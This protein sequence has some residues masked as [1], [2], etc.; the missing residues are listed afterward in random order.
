MH[1]FPTFCYDQNGAKQLDK[2]AQEYNLSGDILMKRAAVAALAKLREKWPYAK[3]IKIFCGVG[4]NAG[5]GF[6]LARLAQ[7][8]GMQVEIITIEQTPI[9]RDEAKNAFEQALNKGIPIASFQKSIDLQDT[10]VI[11][12]AIFGIGLT[13]DV[14]GLYAEAIMLINQ[15][16]IP[17]FSIDIPSGLSPNTGSCLGIAIDASATITF[18]ALKQGLLTNDGPDKTGELY[19][20]SLDVPEEIYD[21]V[22]PTAR[23][24]TLDNIHS[25]LAPRLRNAHKGLYGHVLMVGGNQGFAGAMQIS[26][27]GAVRVGAGL[28]SIATHPL[29]ASSIAAVRPELMSHAVE[30]VD[31]MKLLLDRATVIAIGPGLGQDAWAQGLLNAVINQDKPLVVDADALNQLALNPH[32]NDRWILTPH[33]GEAARLLHC[34]TAEIQADRFAAAE[35]IQRTYGG[36][37][38][39]KGC[40]TIVMGDDHVAWICDA[41]N[42]GMASGG[43]GDLL[44]GIIAGLVAQKI[45]LLEA[46]IAGVLIHALAG[47]EAAEGGERGLLATD[48]LEYLREWVN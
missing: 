36:V 25:V 6:V 37:V 17:V 7:E 21:R 23:I 18:I 29:H 10:D 19:F 44:T 2:T 5:D 14:T 12:D 45:G 16:F 11:V 43:M 31:D 47:D 26:G 48:V 15:S 35:K 39:L 20:D 30:T 32:R 1:Y 46:A 24:V 4:N 40:G 8:E 28:V 27:E 9:L 33:P 42:P 34:S 22:K 38:V 41:G 3:N 13:R